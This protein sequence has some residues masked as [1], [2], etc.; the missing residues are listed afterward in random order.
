MLVV[1]CETGGHVTKW[2]ESCKECPE[3]APVAHCVSTKIPLNWQ[4]PRGPFSLSTFYHPQSKVNGSDS[5]ASSTRKRQVTL[6]CVI[7][8]WSKAKRV[9]RIEMDNFRVGITGV[10]TSVGLTRSGNAKLA[11]SPRE[12][13]N[14]RNSSMDF[15]DIYAGCGGL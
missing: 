5:T 14:T 13:S 8:P 12:P 1:I 2:M 15:Q 6:S 4:E 11:I 7:P 10:W 3:G 9:Y